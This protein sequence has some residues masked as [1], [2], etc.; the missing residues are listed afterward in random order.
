MIAHVRTPI[1]ETRERIL[2][3]AEALLRQHGVSK[4]A[5]V[6]VARAAGMGHAN[7]YKHF[8]SKAALLE[9]VGSRWLHGIAAQLAALA[10]SDGPVPDRLERWVL[11][12]SDAKRR[13]FVE[14]PLLFETY[15][16]VVEGNPAVI[17][18]YLD[19]I[20]GQIAAMIRA[21]VADGDYRV[22]DPDAAAAAVMAAITRFRHPVFVAGGGGQS[23]EADIRPVVALLNGGL[24]VGVI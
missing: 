11:A 1:A 9:A 4:V 6:D 13:K 7:V 3:A 15:R 8:D 14:D 12:L 17:G 20:R 22:T 2:A 23:M 19:T 24:A 16:V 5:V 10:A 21:G 18:G